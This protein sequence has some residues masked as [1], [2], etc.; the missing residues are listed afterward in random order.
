MDS[1]S[2]SSQCTQLTV[3]SRFAM[4]VTRGGWTC[5]NFTNYKM[6]EVTLIDLG[7]C[8]VESSLAFV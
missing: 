6:A 7:Y 2:A 8:K 1:L 3:H 5:L 4:V